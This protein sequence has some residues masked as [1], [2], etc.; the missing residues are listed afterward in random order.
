MK[1]EI[2]LNS[3]INKKELSPK[4]W[5]NIV[6]HFCHHESTTGIM[7]NCFACGKGVPIREKKKTRYGY[8]FGQFSNKRHGKRGW[9]PRFTSDLCEE[10]ISWIENKLN[11]KFVRSYAP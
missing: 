4:Y 1:K 5:K 9:H 7:S 8:C 2:L 11:Y 3:I 6:I 10:C